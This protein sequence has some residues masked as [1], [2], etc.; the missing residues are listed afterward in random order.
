[1]ILQEVFVIINY[2]ILLQKLKAIRF[3]ESTI[4][5]FKSYLPERIILVNVENKLSDFGKISCGVPQG[6][7]LGYL[8]FL[9]YNSDMSQVVTSTLLIYGDN[10]YILYQQKGRRKNKK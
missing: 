10:L 8:L 6:S 4:N 1:M 9:I 7:I 3:P 2:E 5:W